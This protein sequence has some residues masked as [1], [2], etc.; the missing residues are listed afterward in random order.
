MLI[1]S[2]RK[3][4]IL[5]FFAFGIVLFVLHD[6]PWTTTTMSRFSISRQQLR[7]AL[8]D[9]DGSTAVDTSAAEYGSGKEQQ[10]LTD[11]VYG[12]D[13]VKAGTASS[14]LPWQKLELER[15]N[16]K[17]KSVV[18]GSEDANRTRLTS[19]EEWKEYLRGMLKW[20]RPEWEGHWPPFGDYKDREYDP[21]RW[22][23]FAV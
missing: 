11:S 17:K 10:Q 2:P 12:D 4:A 23:E 1:R 16:G 7:L 8:F 19:V 3:L 13:G 6:A 14:M 15:Q 5:S 22:E 21:N 9:T 18:D 20:P